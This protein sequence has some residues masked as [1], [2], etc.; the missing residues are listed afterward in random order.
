MS[1]YFLKEAICF[2]LKA[3]KPLKIKNPTG[4][5]ISVAKRQGAINN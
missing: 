5:N 1:N 4:P 3:F 2:R